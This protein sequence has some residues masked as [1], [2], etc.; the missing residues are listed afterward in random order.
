M[1]ESFVEWIED[2]MDMF[3]KCL[4]EVE[5]CVDEGMKQAWRQIGMMLCL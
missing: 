4:S 2:T 3:E 1:Q 5:T